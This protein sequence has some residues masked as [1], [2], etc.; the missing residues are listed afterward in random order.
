MAKMTVSDATRRA[1]GLIERLTP[2]ELVLALICITTLGRLV[3]SAMIGLG[4]DEIYTVATSRTFALSTFDHPPLA[5]WLSG[6]AAW[7]T[8]SEHPVVVR[9]PFITLFAATTWFAFAAGRALFN[10]HAGVY[11]A[12]VLNLAPVIG[13]TTGSFV[14]PDGPLLAGMMATVFA[15]S[16]ALFGA[17][18]TA[19]RWWL[20]AGAA[21][22][23]ACLA[24]LHGVFLLAG[25]GL[26]L[27]TSPSHRFW[28]LRPWPYLAGGVALLLFTPVI[29]WNIEHDWISFAFQ[30]GRA[31]ATKLRLSGP[32]IALGGQALFV[33]P[34]LWAPLVLSLYYAART[35][36]RDPR[37]WFVF[38][39]AIGPIAAFTLVAL[40]GTHVLFHWAAPGYAIAA[41]LL[42][43]DI[44]DVQAGKWGSKRVSTMWL[45]ATAAS[46]V[47]IL[48][49]VLAIARLPWPTGQF[50]GVHAPPYPLTETIA[51]TEVRR[52]L[53][54]RGLLDDPEVFVAATRWHEAARLDWALQGALTVYC[55]SSDPRGYG[56]IRDTRTMLGRDA[57]II[58][59]NLDPLR[60]RELLAPYFDALQDFPPI[61]V[62]RA[63]QAVMSVGV[64]RGTRLR[65]SGATPNLIEPFAK[66]AIGQAR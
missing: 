46:V 19:P 12:L 17:H 38:C 27:V 34:W 52:A 51:W 18:E 32:L 1:T 2:V 35:A 29:I 30:A 3:L 54:D 4:I 63:G 10:A 26:F 23:F 48:V 39:L 24:K 22:G 47:V 13:W 8:G 15:L 66:T 43:R 21:A 55:L 59:V 42:G 31:R 16:R 58:G 33:L 11:A 36:T 62:I 45:K 37:G 60:T 28:L 53:Q 9:L 7:I 49:V 41:L 50:A 64:M 57:L 56:V 61:N 40:N 6:A 14:L 44:V 65:A 25:T 20:L 5:W